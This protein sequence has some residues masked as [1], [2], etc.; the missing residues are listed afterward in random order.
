M[1]LSKNEKLPNGSEEGLQNSKNFEKG[2]EKAKLFQKK[3]GQISLEYLLVVGLTTIIVIFLLA[4]SGYYS[5]EVETTI[6]TNQIDAIAKEI[7]DTA[8]SMYYF[9]EPSK[10]T[11]KVFIPRGIEEINVS[12]NELNFKVRTQSGLTDMFYRS[13]VPLQGGISYS[14]GL[15][16]V[17]VEA[18]GGYVWI[19]GT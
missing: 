9:G 7:V 13:S 2:L 10:T 4:I 8:E 5:R 18:R 16:Y 3:R 17:I 1:K 15:H 14:Y 19:N 6:N 11:I 12:A